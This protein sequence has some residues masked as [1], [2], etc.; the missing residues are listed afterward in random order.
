VSLAYPKPE[1]KRLPTFVK[2]VR[3]QKCVACP[4]KGQVH[5]VRG[6]R[7]GDDANLVPLCYICHGEY[8]HWGRHTWRERRG[9]NLLQIAAQLYA[10][11]LDT[12]N[13]V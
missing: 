7:F 10:D 3:W 6:R 11:W 5:H 8:N 12:Q 13:G 1:T 4:R 9:V 2:W